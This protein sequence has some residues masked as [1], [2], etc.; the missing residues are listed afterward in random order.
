MIWFSVKGPHGL[1]REG[2]ED[3]EVFSLA[4]HGV[5]RAMKAVDEINCH[6]S[7]FD[8]IHRFLRLGR[9]G[10]VHGRA[11]T[12]A[13]RARL[14]TA[15]GRDPPQTGEADCALAVLSHR[16]GLL[17][18]WP[19]VAVEH[20]LGLVRRDGAQDHETVAEYMAI[21]Y[22]RRSC[23]RPRGRRAGDLN[24]LGQP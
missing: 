4:S 21:Q 14:A 7:D 2:L 18:C 10:E 22:R 8:L 6:R 3:S 15:A 5:E 13:G 20:N 23:P 11:R 9:G 1:D 16:A 24:W 12:R 19:P 17:P